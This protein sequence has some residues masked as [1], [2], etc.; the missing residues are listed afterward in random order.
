MR[1]TRQ[2][3]ATVTMLMV[4]FT[5]LAVPYNQDYNTFMYNHYQNNWVDDLDWAQWSNY[6]MWVDE[7]NDIADCYQCGGSAS[8][9]SY[10]RHRPDLGLNADLVAVVTHGTHTGSGSTYRGRAAGWPAHEWLNSRTIRPLNGE[11]E[12][13]LWSACSFLTT[14]PNAAWYGFRNAHRFGALV[15]AGCYG[16]CSITYTGVNSTWNEI[17]D[18]IADDRAAIWT[19]WQR[20]A[21]VGWLDDDVIIY[22]LGR[23]GA[24]NCDNRARNVSLQNRLDY[25]QYGYGLDEPPPSNANSK[26]FCGYFVANL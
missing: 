19:A 23:V 9:E 13:Y 24:N 22:G 25:H 12:I 3:V 7:M 8:L 10:I 17:G 5:A 16:P 2:L 11:V 1:S 14:D 20:G 21:D 15:S 18:A 26:E 6:N 4:P